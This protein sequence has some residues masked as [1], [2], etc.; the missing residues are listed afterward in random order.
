MHV[1]PS[2]RQGKPAKNVVVKALQLNC[3]F[4]TFLGDHDGV[5]DEHGVFFINGLAPAETDRIVTVGVVPA[6]IRTTST[7]ASGSNVELGAIEIP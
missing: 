4:D 5:T 3:T 2:A 1:R 6:E 7:G